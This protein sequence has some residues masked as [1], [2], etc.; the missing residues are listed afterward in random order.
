MKY[1][2]FNSHSAFDRQIRASIA[3][4]ADY[5]SIDWYND[6]K[7][8]EDYLKTYSN[9]SNFP[10][11]VDIETKEKVI[12]SSDI[13]TAEAELNKLIELSKAD[14]ADKYKYKRKDQYEKSGLTAENWMVAYVQK[15]LDED[16]TQWD[17][18]VAQRANIKTQFPKEEEE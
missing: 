9:P 10:C 6:K 18:L 15:E 13:V 7:G 16:S 3:T 12:I 17:A 14:E 11:I 8:R 4:K 2:I 5:T 1:L